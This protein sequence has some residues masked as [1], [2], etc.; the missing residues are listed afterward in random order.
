MLCE[1]GLPKYFWAEAVN[2]ACYVTNRALIR[3]LLKKTPYELLNGKKLS[4]EH[5]RTF[6]RKCFVLN[7]GKEHLEKFD[8]KPD[9]GMFLGYDSNSSYYKV[10]NKRTLTVESSVHVTFDETN[11]PKAEKNSSFDDRLTD[12]LE[13]FNLTKVD[14]GIFLGYDSNSILT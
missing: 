13:D 12:E 9:E 1:N 4:V 7:N 5:F 6:G 8:S 10:F 11:L 2:T 3:P 14:E